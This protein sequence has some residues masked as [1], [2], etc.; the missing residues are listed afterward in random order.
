MDF[1]TD[2]VCLELKNRKV[3]YFRINRDEFN[4]YKITLTIN[5]LSLKVEF[6]EKT[7]LINE[8]HLKSVYFRAPI[9]LRELNN[10]SLGAEEQ[11]YRSQWMAFIRN[12]TIFEKVNW[13]N[14]P[15]STF[16]AENKLLQLKYAS[17]LGFLCPKTIV[18]N[19]SSQR[20]I[21]EDEFIVKSIDTA[22]LN[23]DGKEAFVYS[24]IVNFEEF[25]NSDLSLSPIIVQE[26]IGNKIDV[27]VTVV[28]NEVF[29]VKIVKD[30][31]GVEGDWRLHKDD[32]QFTPFSLPQDISQKCIKLVES[33]GLSFGAIDLIES[34][35]KYYFI[36]VNPTGEWAWLVESANFAIPESICN[37]IM[38]KNNENS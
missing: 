26:Y 17:E 10:G 1:T 35:S 11:L 29:S 7:Y 25:T 12:L 31:K 4:Y 23:V 34:D 19:T 36:E 33:F 37:L 16:K 24:N 18:T 15:I 38:R 3:S 2:Y 20:V 32:V 8:S 22:L 13:V 9:Y 6:N 28:G 5:P 30:N 27:R 21:D 14:N